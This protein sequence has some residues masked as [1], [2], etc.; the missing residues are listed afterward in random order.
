VQTDG[1]DE[2]LVVIKLFANEQA[3]TALGRIRAGVASLSASG[4]DYDRLLARHAALHRELFMR[5]RLDLR[6][7]D[8]NRNLPNE[9]LVNEARHG[10]AYNA[11]FERLFDFGRYA[12]I[13]S[14][15]ADGMPAPAGLP[16]AGG[17]WRR[18]PEPHTAWP[19]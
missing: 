14:S 3:R 9:K 12:L 18:Y 17:F 13:C 15:A 2:V 19:V 8:R 7:A 5:T 6:A 1:S 11:L 4:L 10:Q 16:A